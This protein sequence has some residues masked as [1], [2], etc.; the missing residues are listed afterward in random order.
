MSRTDPKIDFGYDDGGVREFSAHRNGGWLE[1]AI[2]PQHPLPL[3]VYF[4]ALGRRRVGGHAPFD[5]G[6]LAEVLVSTAGVVPDRRRVSEAIKRCVH[7]GYL[8][9]GS[10]ALCLVVPTDDVQGGKGAEYRCRKAHRVRSAQA[11]RDGCECARCSQVSVLERTPDPQV[12]VSDVDTSPPSV[13]ADADTLSGGPLFYLST[14]TDDN[15][16]PDEGTAA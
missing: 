9:P 1:K 11:H 3:R 8:M 15:A 2:N 6:E 12:S 5:P 4:A 14:G 16:G 7:W 13:R 10:D